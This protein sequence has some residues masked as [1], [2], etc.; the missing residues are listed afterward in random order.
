M[1]KNQEK[2]LK[3]ASKL[4]KLVNETDFDSSKHPKSSTSQ[5]SEDF[6]DI[7]F[8]PCNVLTSQPSEDFNA[9]NKN[10][11]KDDIAKIDDNLEKLKRL[12]DYYGGKSELH[13]S[14]KDINNQVISEIKNY[15][16]YEIK[17]VKEAN[18]RI[19]NLKNQISDLN[20]E[21]HDETNIDCMFLSCH[22][23]VSE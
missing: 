13:A 17:K 2:V 14:F 22:V 1:G 6:E 10:K 15:N 7:S 12:K 21:L 8:S 18:K 4:K 9:L 23:R 19:E 16:E 5:Q 11:I 20:K 3:Y